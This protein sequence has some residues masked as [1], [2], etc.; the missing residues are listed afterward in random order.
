M[1]V[2]HAG[3]TFKSR[4]EP[5]LVCFTNHPN[6]CHGFAM[7][8]S[9]NCQPA[10]LSYAKRYYRL[11]KAEA[12]HMANILIIEPNSDTSMTLCNWL[13]PDGHDVEVT[14]N[15]SD[16]QSA[17][18]RAKF[19]LIVFNWDSMLQANLDAMR[20]IENAGSDT[21]NI[22][23]VD[24]PLSPAYRAAVLD[25]GA[26][27]CL[28]K[29]FHML[30]FQARVRSVLR[31][32]RPRRSNV[33]LVDD[34]TLDTTLHRVHKNGHELVLRPKEFALLEFL[35]QNHGQIYSPEELLKLVW[36]K[37]PDASIHAVRTCIKRIRETLDVDNSGITII[38]TVPKFGYRVRSCHD[39]FSIS[40]V[41]QHS[42]TLL[43][44]VPPTAVQTIVNL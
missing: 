7:L 9:S 37:D 24:M 3:T 29:P 8:L 20:W 4:T 13:E 36:S 33:L 34:V 28:S 18:R 1:L 15:L 22:V 19:D 10:A 42:Q 40:A 32:N 30:E 38:E 21:A 43:S 12:R 23:L 25:C 39:K 11:V 5:N 31:R 41:E 44:F 17:S 27:D 2:S 35:M 6:R 14:Q 26:D 16:A